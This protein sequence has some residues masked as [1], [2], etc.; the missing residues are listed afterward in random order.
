MSHL[1]PS[2]YNTIFRFSFL[3]IGSSMYAVYHKQYA[4]SLCPAGVFLTSIHYWRKP[5]PWSRK[6]DMTYVVCSLLYQLY[7]A[8]RSTYRIQYYTLTLI[9]GSMYPLAIYYSRQKR[10]WHSTYA[11]CALHVIAN[12]ANL[13]LYSGTFISP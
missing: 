5:E 9:A 2:Q 13:V 1:L 6:L 11:H 12:V 10:Y 7:Q 4:L 3:S 8:Y